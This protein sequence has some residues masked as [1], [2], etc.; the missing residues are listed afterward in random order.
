MGVHNSTLLVLC[1]SLSVIVCAVG[2]GLTIPPGS[3][4]VA[5]LEGESV[6]LVCGT[7]LTGNPI[8]TITWTD[9]TGRY[10]TG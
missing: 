4:S 10:N 3:E 7:N 1:V 9:N 8:P 5:V 6:T 2:A